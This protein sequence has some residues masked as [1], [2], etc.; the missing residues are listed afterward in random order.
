MGASTGQKIQP[1][2]SVRDL[3]ESA[4][5]DLEAAGATVVE[6]DFP[7]V[8]NYEADR[9]GAPN[10][11]NRGIVPEEFFDCEIWQLSM[12]SWHEFLAAQ[13][14]KRLRLRIPLLGGGLSF[15]N[16]GGGLQSLMLLQHFLPTPPPSQEGFPAPVPGAITKNPPMKGGEE[17]LS[18]FFPVG[19]RKGSINLKFGQ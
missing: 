11:F 16:L 1:R 9:A 6:I 12:W 14:A 19:S 4:R 2:P 17:T 15:G 7:V 8:T 13:E 10:V 18:Y 3:W 5:V